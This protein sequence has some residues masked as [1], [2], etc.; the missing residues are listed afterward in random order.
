VRRN[1]TWLLLVVLALSLAACGSSPDHP[2]GVYGIAVT[3]RAGDISYPAPSPSPLP[4]GFGLSD[5]IPATNAMIVVKAV[6]GAQSGVVVARVRSGGDGT[7]RVTLPPGIYKP[8]GTAPS[9][10]RKST[11]VTVR[12]GAY[13]RAV[14]LAYVRY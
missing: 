12:S 10:V 5:S 1:L 14:V 11:V 13:A 7:F 4:A 9:P 3:N 2:S 8:Y 6:G